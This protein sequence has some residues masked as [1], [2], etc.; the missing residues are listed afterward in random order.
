M[1]MISSMEAFPGFG[2][3]KN[4]ITVEAYS[5]I[6]NIRIHGKLFIKTSSCSTEFEYNKN[7]PIR[8]KI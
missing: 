3:S 5:Y 4:K 6:S 2:S 7:T 1:V 8:W